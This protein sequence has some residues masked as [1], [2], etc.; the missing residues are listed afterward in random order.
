MSTFNVKV[1][2]IES[3][4]DHPNADKLEIAHMEGTSYQSCVGIGEFEEGDLVAY[5]PPDALVPEDI[6]EELGVKGYLA[7]PDH[8]RVKSIR[9]RGTLSQGLL[10]PARDEWEKGQDVQ[11]ELGIGEYEPPIPTT[12][13]GQ[14]YRHDRSCCMKYDIENYR[15]YPDAF[16]ED[17]EVA[18]T[19]KLHGTFAQHALVSDDLSHDEHG[20]F[21]VGSKGL[22]SD[23]KPFRPDADDNENNLYLRCAGAYDIQSKLESARSDIEEDTIFVLGEI[24]GNSVQD[25]GYG[26]NPKRGDIGYRV[27]DVYVGPYMEG[28]FLGHEE[29]NR[30]CDEYGF[31]RV[32][33]LYEGPFDEETM[34]DYASGQETITGDGKHIREGIIVRPVEERWNHDLGRVQLKAKSPDY[35]TRDGGTEYR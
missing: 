14:V 35:V 16:N 10:Y 5:I 17:E 12:L 19:E 32:P 27:F 22:L 34:W 20:P 25:L 1:R 24:F 33:V 6:Q 18:F 13:N 31:E 7:G 28:R 8:N 9:L 30:F 2:E 11:E 3:I 4:E 15:H 29:L 26:R 21:V 23:R